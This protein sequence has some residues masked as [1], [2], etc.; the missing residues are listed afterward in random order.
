MKT[1]VVSR[2]AFLAFGT[3][4]T[5]ATCDSPVQR[6]N[7]TSLSNE[8]RLAWVDAEKCLTTHDAV[9]GLFDAATTLWDEQQYLH[10]TMSNYIHGVGQFLPWHRYYVKLHEYLLQTYCNYTGGMPYWDLQVDA[11]NVTQSVVWDLVYGVGGDG[12]SS[13]SNVVTDGPFAY[14]EFHVGAYSFN[15]VIPKAATYYLNRSISESIFQLASQPSVDECNEAEVYEDY[16][17]C[18][19]QAP[20]SAGHAGTGGVMQDP[21]LSPGDP[22]FFLHHNNLDRLWWEWQSMNLTA[23]LT[24]ISGQNTPSDSFNLQNSW[25]APGANFTD[26]SG[27]PANVTTLTHVLSLFEMLP[28]VTVGDVMDIGGD[29]ICAEYV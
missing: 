17:D 4:V 20:H 28:N 26:Y 2:L 12:N 6:K 24:D 3:V 25:E 9:F 19:G 1:P 22:I 29:V 13:E 27:D 16:W 14:T 7:F 5:A 18:L 15:T 23:R 10:L 8:E 21:V 11:D